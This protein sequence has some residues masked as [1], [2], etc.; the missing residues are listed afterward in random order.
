MRICVRKMLALLMVFSL[1]FSMLCCTVGAVVAAETQEGRVTGDDV[2]VRNN[3]GT[4]GTKVLTRLDTGTLVTVLG[5]KND[6]DGDKWYYIQTKDKQY[7]GYMYNEYI[8][9]IEDIDYTPDADFEAY[10]TAQK[11][12]ESYKEGLRQLHA[13]YP[14]WV[15]VAQHLP[16]TW[17]E[18]LAAEAEVGRSLVDTDEVIASWKSMEYGAYDWDKKAYVWFDSGG[19]V[20]A[21]REVVA[22]YMDPR[23]FLD[24][25]S[26]FQFES[27]AY[28]S[29][30]TV[31]G[32]QK[33]LGG[34]CFMYSMAADFVDAAKQT[35]VSAYHLA[36]RALQEQGMEGNWLGKGTV[37]NFTKDGVL[38][39]V[40]G[41]YNIF[42]I[43]AYAANGLSATQNGA[44][45]AKAKG[46]DTAK[47]SIIG[48]GQQLG[49]GYINKGQNTLYLQKFDLVDGG[50]GFYNHQYMTNIAA[51]ASEAKLMKKA[52]TDEM[53]K[54]ALV[55]NIPVFS[56]MPDKPQALPTS[57]GNNDNTLTDLSVEGYKITPTFSRYTTDYA[58]TVDKSVTQVKITATKSDSSAKVEGGGTITLSGEETVADIKVTA[59]SG[60]VRTYTVSIHRPDGA[61]APAD[62]VIGESK[63]TFNTYLTGVSPDTTAADLLKNIPVTNGTVQLVDASG[64]AVSGKVA[65]GHKLQV[66]TGSTVF[67]TYPVVVYGDVSGDGVVSSKD[68]LMAQKHIL[69]I[70]KIA[71]A[72]LTAA[73][74]SKDG[75]L[76]SSDLLRTQ[77]QILGITKPII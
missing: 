7:T 2:A 77:K 6:S 49:N 52:Y 19:W 55:F 76:T 72:Y 41:Y 46:W 58:I 22:Y 34:K 63:Y 24:E 14:N 23:N 43:G 73:D 62:P 53:L 40:T 56:G 70:T 47:K 37:P 45:Y 13:K 36:S 10:L 26:I 16:K 9:I 8:E 65:T 68:L 59:P 11:F 48:G 4:Q 75:K 38:Q 29:V 25:V 27:L 20:S 54:S 69:G 61:V 51:A 66:M 21:Q 5:S 3:P 12:P 32:V 42:D 44:T 1:L 31:E 28:S 74:S 71:G 33:I 64:K 15:F 60:L 30:H 57:K 39:E 67:A 18:A 35:G 50:N 17:S